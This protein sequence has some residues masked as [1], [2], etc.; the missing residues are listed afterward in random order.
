MN[1]DQISMSDSYLL[2]EA[3]SDKCNGA[4][5]RA[6][7]YVQYTSISVQWECLVVLN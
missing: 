4:T 1:Q 3:L 5:P 6:R 2:Y 7:G